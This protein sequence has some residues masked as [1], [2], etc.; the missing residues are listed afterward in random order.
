MT[1]LQ[2]KV[3]VLL[4]GLPLLGMTELATPNQD[5]TFAA[6]DSPPWYIHS[7]AGPATGVIP[8]YTQQLSNQTGY[9]VSIVP[10][11]FQ[12]VVGS[13]EDKDIDFVVSIEHPLLF[14]T[15]YPYMKLGKISALVYSAK[16]LHD[17]LVT[18]G[19]HKA[20]VGVL[21][22]I[23]P[24]IYKLA[25]KELTDSWDI[26]EFNSEESGFRAAQ[27][28]RLDAAILTRNVYEYLVDEEGI[29]EPGHV[30]E[31]GFFKVFAWLPKHIK[32]NYQL[33]KMRKHI[34]EISHD[35]R[36]VLDWRT[37][38]NRFEGSEKTTLGYPELNDSDNTELGELFKKITPH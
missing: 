22:G 1:L 4:L 27:L 31:L 33:I 14:E 7:E 32:L 21:R 9:T 26:I 23:V 18:E 19:R 10:M 12:R 25:P 6:Y 17:L 36:M 28:G 34:E 37:A 20:R 24:L 13:T 15:A 3:A 35:G 2:C 29:S 16:P 38:L 30:E 5:V 8:Y 11:P